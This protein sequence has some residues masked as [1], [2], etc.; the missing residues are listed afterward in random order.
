MTD[1]SG[2]A[3]IENDPANQKLIADQQAAAAAGNVEGEA[4]DA[5][6]PREFSPHTRWVDDKVVP[7]V[8]FTG[9][10]YSYD[11]EA[12]ALARI[13]ATRAADKYV[14]CMDA[15]SGAYLLENGATDWR[16]TVED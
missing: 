4:A 6:Y 15:D 9:T 8:T 2:A 11:T 13:D 12:E 10:Q 16:I 5:V 3:A 1:L 7:N 14:M